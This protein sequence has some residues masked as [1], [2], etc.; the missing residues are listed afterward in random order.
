M[1][2]RGAGSRR[3][4]GGVS[5][6]S[7]RDLRRLLLD[8]GLVRSADEPSITRWSNGPGDVYAG[9]RHGYDKVLLVESGSIRFD[10][11][12]LGRALD[13]D[14]GERLDLPAGTLHAATV[15]S[16]GVTCV[17]AHLAA[18]SLPPETATARRS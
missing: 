17:E 11:P 5:A 3:P 2:R 16:P 15:G 4:S 10:L 1:A 14:A 18:G 7:E 9:H 6:L 12:E 8:E 13:L